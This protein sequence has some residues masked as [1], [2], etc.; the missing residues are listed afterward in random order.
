MRCAGEDARG[1]ANDVFFWEGFSSDFRPVLNLAVS[2]HYDEFRGMLLYSLPN[3]GNSL[4][5]ERFPISGNSEVTC[6][7]T[8]QLD[9]A[10]LAVQS[11]Q[12]VSLIIAKYLVVATL[13]K[14][15]H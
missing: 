15:G 13:A 14:P 9:Y 12:L 5:L 1:Q 4:L 2:V 11:P 6:C 8:R 10:G 3:H 7:E